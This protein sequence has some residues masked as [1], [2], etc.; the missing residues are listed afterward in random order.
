[1]DKL[2][3]TAKDVTFDEV[4]IIIRIRTPTQAGLQGHGT[5]FFTKKEPLHHVRSGL[6][7][8]TSQM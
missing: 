4:I 5:P 8:Y 1:M 3:E 6:K 7:L 2:L